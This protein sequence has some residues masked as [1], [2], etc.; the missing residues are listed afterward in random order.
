VWY[1]I[2][3]DFVII[4]IRAVPNSSKNMVSGILDDSL[5]LKIK[6]PA[7]EGAANKELIRFLSKLFKVS[8]SDILFVNGETSKRK[9]I[10]FPCNQQIKDF[11]KELENE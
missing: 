8:K 7:V 10:S 11:I 6:A 3:N 9:R 2:K 4:D 5:K 1:E